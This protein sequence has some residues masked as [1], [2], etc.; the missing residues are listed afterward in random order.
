MAVD[1]NTALKTRRSVYGLSKEATVSDARIEEILKDAVKHSPSAFNS[2]SGRVILL[3]GDAHEELWDELKSILRPLTPE[4]AF[5]KTIE[6]LEGFR[7]A[8]GTVLFFEDQAVVQ[9]LQERFALYK[10]K[11]PIWSGNSTGMLQFVAWT[12]LAIEG[13]GASL[14]HYDPLVD[15]WVRKR[16][17]VPATWKL[18]AEMPFGKPIAPAGEKEFLPLE[19]R[20]RVVR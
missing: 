18:T 8:H 10:E 13:M 11:F 6:K 20:F 12:S 3:L 5:P 17:G 7:A 2:Q 16:T 1:F 4:A 14:Q 19:G 15:E 9:G